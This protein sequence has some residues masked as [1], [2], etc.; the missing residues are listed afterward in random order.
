M[1]RDWSYVIV[2]IVSE[3]THSGS[4]DPDRKPALILSPLKSADFDG[5]IFT[6]NVIKRNSK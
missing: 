3:Q 4:Q 1:R 5:V 6:N 2:G